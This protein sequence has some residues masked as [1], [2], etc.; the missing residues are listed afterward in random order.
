GSQDTTAVLLTSRRTHAAAE[1]RSR[2]SASKAAAPAAVP[3]ECFASLEARLNTEV[4]A[5]EPPRARII[6]LHSTH[7]RRSRDFLGA[8]RRLGAAGR[9]GADAAGGLG[10]AGR[11]GADAAGG[12]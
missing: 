7:R 6:R 1:A 11:L 3:P 5:A 10:A 4:P 2:A 9:L 12:L 8:A